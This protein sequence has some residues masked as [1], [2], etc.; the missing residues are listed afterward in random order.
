VS[1]ES[2]WD[3]ASDTPPPPLPQHIVEQTRAR[4]IEAYE[5]LTGQAF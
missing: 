4:Y 2:G 5:M 3:R 1:S